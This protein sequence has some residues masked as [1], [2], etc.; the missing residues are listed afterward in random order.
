VVN[1]KY[2]NINR[3]GRIVTM[4]DDYRADNLVEDEQISIIGK[5]LEMEAAAPSRYVTTVAV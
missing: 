5:T 4:V 3:S 1:K 2:E